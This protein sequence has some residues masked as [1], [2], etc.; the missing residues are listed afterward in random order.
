MPLFKAK[1]MGPFLSSSNAQCLMNE[2]ESKVGHM[3]VQSN[4]QRN[5]NILCNWESDMLKLQG[6]DNWVRT[7]CKYLLGLNVIC[8]PPPHLLG[9]AGLCQI[10]PVSDLAC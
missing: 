10:W 5:L 1:H 2:S 9:L 4:C 6:Y 3:H 7:H 8:Y